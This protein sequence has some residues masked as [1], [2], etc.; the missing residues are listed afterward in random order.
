MS[1]LDNSPESI[2]IQQVAVKLGSFLLTKINQPETVSTESTIGNVVKDPFQEQLDYYEIIY[3]KQFLKFQSS[4]PRKENGDALI[5]LIDHPLL[6]K[7]QTPSE[8]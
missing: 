6:N 8:I 5:K 3:P 4:D 1:S 2:A 7:E